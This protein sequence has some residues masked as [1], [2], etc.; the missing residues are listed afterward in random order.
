V[1]IRHAIA[2][3]LLCTSA[4][5]HDLRIEHVTIVSPERAAPMHDAS[6]TIRGDRIVAI[7]SSA[8]AA[9]GNANAGGNSAKSAVLD[10]TAMVPQHPRAQHPVGRGA[11]VA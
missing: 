6:V 1:R 2:M 10:G 9:G 4:V 11:A 5:A 3:G 7:E 8:N